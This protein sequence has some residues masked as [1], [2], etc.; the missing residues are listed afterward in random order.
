MGKRP[1]QQKLIERILNY[2]I[3]PKYFVGRFSDNVYVQNLR[4]NAIERGSK[5]NQYLEGYNGTTSYFHTFYANRR[6]PVLINCSSK[7]DELLNNAIANPPMC[8]K[9]LGASRCLCDL[10]A[11]IQTELGKDIRKDAG[12]C[13]FNDELKAIEKFLLVIN[14]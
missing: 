13:C 14:T 4:R 3:S 6:D 12:W 2:V 7:L 9:T 11:A 5:P 1:N 10:Y 8:H